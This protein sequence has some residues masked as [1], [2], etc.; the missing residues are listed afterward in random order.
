MPA[1]GDLERDLHRAAEQA[2]AV[3]SAKP[4]QR[5]LPRLIEGLLQPRNSPTAITYAMLGPNRVVLV[6]EYRNLAAGA[7]FRTD[8]DPEVV[9]DLIIG[10]MLNH[11]LVTGTAPSAAYAAALVDVL[12]EGLRAQN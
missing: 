2:R 3:L 10:P 12:L 11:L 7:G 9:P 5:L 1:S 6:D 8:L 4:F